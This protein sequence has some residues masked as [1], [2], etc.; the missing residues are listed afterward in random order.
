MGHHMRGQ[1]LLLLL[2]YSQVRD[3]RLPSRDVLRCKSW[4][5]ATESSA[6]AEQLRLAGSAQVDV[7][8]QAK[9]GH[10]RQA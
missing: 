5:L 4:P 2:A 7:T 9:T 1:L 10:R 3:R 8:L 6:H